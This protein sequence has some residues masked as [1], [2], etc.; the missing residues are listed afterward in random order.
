M[1]ISKAPGLAKYACVGPMCDQCLG[2]LAYY[3]IHKQF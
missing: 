2:I 1:D 3:Q